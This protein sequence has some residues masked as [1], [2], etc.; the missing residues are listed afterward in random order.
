MVYFPWDVMMMLFAE[1]YS[2]A[3]PLFV[4]QPRWMIQLIAHATRQTDINWWHLRPDNVGR[5]SATQQRRDRRQ[6]KRVPDT[7]C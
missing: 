2:M 1:M 4:P 5:P 7:G 6:E 3:I